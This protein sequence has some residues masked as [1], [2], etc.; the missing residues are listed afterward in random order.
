MKRRTFL[1]SAA[2]VA[3]SGTLDVPLGRIAVRAQDRVRIQVSF[4][5][6]AFQPVMQALIDKFHERV[7][8]VEIRIQTPVQTWDA[9]LQ[10]TILDMRTG[11]AAELA[12]QGYNRL[13][14]VAD[15]KAA[16]PLDALIVRESDWP[17]QGFSPALMSLGKLHG[18]QWG[19][20][21]QISNPVIFYNVDLFREAGVDPQTFVA[22]W[23]SVT[24]A[25]KKIA[26]L[27]GGKMGAF[28]DY[29]AD[30]NWM[31]QALLFSLGGRMM[32]PDEKA[33]AFDDAAGLRALQ[34]LRKFGEAGQVD[35]TVDQAGQS[36]A[37][38]VTGMIFTSNRRLGTYQ[39]AIQGRF[40]LGSVAFPKT[41]NGR[42]PVGGGFLSITTLD[43]VKQK[44]AWE[45]LKFAAG[46][47]GQAVVVRMTGAVPGNA[48]A[49]SNLDDYY[50]STPLAKV[51]L[52][53]LP[54]VTGWYSF[55]GPN[56][57]KISDVLFNHLRTVVTLKVTPEEALKSMRIDVG[58]L[59]PKA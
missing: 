57:I 19:L 52:E 58:T 16:V 23:D 9:Q 6:S 4:F 47:A 42:V 43:S 39:K 45:F 41:E 2:A 36:F 38:G 56:A 17:A 27:G 8:E 32:S 10:R 24:E 37:A 33:I 14:I 34:I 1:A 22:T 44:A 49:A 54:I 21:F 11:T 13:R 20:A 40:K 50:T 59:L 25:A 51:G 53:Q 35:M 12:V 28:F 18:Q 31:Y 29:T 30:G 46:S 5:D 48:N 3:L 26:A 15:N 7:P 55:P